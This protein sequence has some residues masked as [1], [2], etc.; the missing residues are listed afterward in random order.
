MI[1]I[2][3]IKPRLTLMVVSLLFL[4]SNVKAALLNVTNWGG[5]E[6]VTN[7]SVSNTMLFDN[8]TAQFGGNSTVSQAMTTAPNYGMIIHNGLQ[9]FILQIGQ[10]GMIMLVSIPFITMYI[11]QGNLMLPALLGML[12][13]LYVGVFI[14]EAYIFSNKDSDI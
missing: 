9:V 8:I 1:N 3:S 5:G 10:P 6:A 4:V 11:V 12:L 2:S 7:F 14:G 13:S